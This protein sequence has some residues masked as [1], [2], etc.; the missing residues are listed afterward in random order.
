ME[1]ISVKSEIP[2]DEDKGME[3]ICMTSA[4]GRSKGVMAL[5]WEVTK[6]RGK[7]VRRWIWSDRICPWEVTHWMKMPAPPKGE[8]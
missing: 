2:K 4:T 5:K 1:W 7:L 6:V 8:K 3:F